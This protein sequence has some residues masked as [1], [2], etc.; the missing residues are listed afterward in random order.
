[1]VIENL[2]N[3]A[4]AEGRP[5]EMFFLGFLYASIAVFLSLWIFHDYASL[6]MV[7]LT[8]F[9]SIPVVYTLIAIEEKKDTS[10][11]SEISLLKEHS[12]A[13]AVLVFLFLGYTVAFSLWFVVLPESTVTNMFNVQLETIRSI[14]AG[15]VTSFSAG[16]GFVMQIFSN[17]IKVMIF[18]IMFA[19]LFGMGAIFILTWNASVI[20]AAIGTFIRNNVASY[21]DAAGL[22]KLTG[23]FHIGSVGLM[24]YMIHG[25]PEILAYFT[26]GLA[27]GIISVAVI[28]HDFGSKNFNKILYDSMDLIV[29]AVLILFIAALIEV[30]ITPVLF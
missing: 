25:I 20:A 27:G 16:T 11:R 29:I 8:V 13:L 17:N 23:Y 7:F 21:A 28:R 12:K 4:K 18:C 30:F 3:P 9:A 5:W 26:A 22:G 15:A 2:V 1:M 14:N 19:F 24:R 6:V 10:G